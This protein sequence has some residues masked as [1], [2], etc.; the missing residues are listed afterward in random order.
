MWEVPSLIR[1]ELLDL[2]GRLARA[3]DSGSAGRFDAQG[4]PS[5]TYMA[6]A[7]RADGSVL[8]RPWIK[9]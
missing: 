2:T 9:E 4:L 6:R 5:G 8:V 1:L 7:F 3:L